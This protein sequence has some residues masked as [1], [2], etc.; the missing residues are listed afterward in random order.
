MDRSSTTARK[1]NGNLYTIHHQE[2]LQANVDYENCVIT[3]LLVDLS[4]LE[5]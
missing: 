5:R 1:R 2:L 4:Q 3:N